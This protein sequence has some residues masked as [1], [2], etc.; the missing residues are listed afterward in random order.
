MLTREDVIRIVRQE[1]RENLRVEVGP[2]NRGRNY[3]KINI[4]LDG[5][6]VASDVF[7]IEDVKTNYYD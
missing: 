2:S 7:D 5:E 1:L 4:L 6:I 3:R